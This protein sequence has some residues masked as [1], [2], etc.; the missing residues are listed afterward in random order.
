MTELQAGQ[1]TL[2]DIFR[3]MSAIQSDVSKALTRLEVI[4][5]RNKTADNIDADHENRIRTL[6]AFRWKLLGLALAISVL[7]GFLAAWLP[8][9]I[10]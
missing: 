2:A 8:S 3:V 6:E 9:H 10:R 5:S 7:T 4:D 1:V